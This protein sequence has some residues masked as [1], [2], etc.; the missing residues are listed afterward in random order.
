MDALLAWATSKKK[1]K[2]RLSKAS[3]L[4]SISSSKDYSGLL[5]LS[6]K[7]LSK[8]FPAAVTSITWRI[9]TLSYLGWT[10]H[11]NALQ[12]CFHSCA[13][14]KNLFHA[15]LTELFWKKCFMIWTYHWSLTLYTVG[16]H[17]FPGQRWGLIIF[18]SKIC[19]CH[20]YRTSCVPEI[21]LEYISSRHKE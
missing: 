15:G 4:I 19:P 16:V 18:I 12:Q 3:F 9:K 6:F 2:E 21:R 8:L 7:I 11:R 14:C 13:M 20:Q 5:V 17:L 10:S 1:N